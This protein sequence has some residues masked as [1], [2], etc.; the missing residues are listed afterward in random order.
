MSNALDMM[1]RLIFEA[2]LAGDRCGELLECLL[3]GG[4]ATVDPDGQLILVD[5]DTLRKMG[6]S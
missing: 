5:A 1:A 3:E 2:A 6:G 4:S